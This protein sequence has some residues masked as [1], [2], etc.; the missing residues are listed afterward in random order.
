MRL[1]GDRERQERARAGRCRSPGSSQLT[2]Q[3]RRAKG[4]DDLQGYKQETAQEQGLTGWGHVG[5]WS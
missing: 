1:E 5:R 4:M 2:Q 3:R